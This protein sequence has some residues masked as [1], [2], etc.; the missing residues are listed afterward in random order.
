M[1]EFTQALKQQAYALVK[2]ASINILG[3]HSTN[4]RNDAQAHKQWVQDETGID[5]STI[6]MLVGTGDYAEEP[7]TVTVIT[8]TTYRRDGEGKLHAIK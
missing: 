6:V 2:H 1:S 5:A 3:F 4:N 8:S 7:D